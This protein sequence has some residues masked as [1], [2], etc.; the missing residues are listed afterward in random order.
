MFETNSMLLK[1]VQLTV[2]KSSK[3]NEYFF[4]DLVH[5]AIAV[6]HNLF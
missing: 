4:I 2:E 1:K 5:F 3:N 6:W